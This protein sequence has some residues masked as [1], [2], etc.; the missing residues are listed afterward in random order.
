MP[1]TKA[2][3]PV[4]ESPVAALRGDELQ[5]TFAYRV[6]ISRMAL[7]RLEQGLLPEPSAKLKRFLPD[8]MTWAQFCEDYKDYQID[9]R[10]ANYGVLTNDPEFTGTIHP[11]IDWMDQSDQAQNLTQVCV[12]LCLHLPTMHRFVMG[13]CPALP[14][15]TLLNALTDAGYRQAVVT[16]FVMS[17]AEWS[18]G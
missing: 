15:E 1:S 17:Y 5:R 12:A 2:N 3:L 18:N 16:D 11:F 10:Q 9:K 13:P 4:M 14:P 6:G 7:L 8:T